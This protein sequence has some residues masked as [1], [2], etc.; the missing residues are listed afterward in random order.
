MTYH[1]PSP[2][3]RIRIVPQSDVTASDP[4]SVPVE[5]SRRRAVPR[6]IADAAGNPARKKREPNSGSFPVGVSGNRNGRPKGARGAK[7]IIRDELTRSLAVPTSRGS[8][9]ITIYQGLVK[10]EISLASEGDHRAR[11]TLLELGRWALE[12]SADA[13]V[14]A[15]QKTP[16]ESS[17]AS[18]AII[19]WFTEEVRTRDEHPELGGEE[20]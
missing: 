10:R 7:T 8:K 12:E 11:K 15:N 6:L 19:D 3:P 5:A 13:P 2:R 4:G 9:K 17:V 14:L 20:A 18:Q 1:V 16:A